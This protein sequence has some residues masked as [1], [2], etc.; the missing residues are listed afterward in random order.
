MSKVLDTLGAR[1]RTLATNPW[2]TCCRYPDEEPEQ[3][4]SAVLDALKAKAESTQTAAWD[5]CCRYPDDEDM[6]E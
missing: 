1:V 5:T 2:D 4:S 3:D 6:E